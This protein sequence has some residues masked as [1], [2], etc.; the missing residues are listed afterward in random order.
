VTDPTSRFRPPD[1]DVL[2]V[3]R[4]ALSRYL[5]QPVVRRYCGGNDIDA[6]CGT[7]AGG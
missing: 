5:G 7:L 4:D 2:K 3:F 1:Y 6:P